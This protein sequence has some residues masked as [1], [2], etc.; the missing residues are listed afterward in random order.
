MLGLMTNNDAKIHAFNMLTQTGANQLAVVPLNIRSDAVVGMSANPDIAG[1]RVT[2]LF[3]TCGPLTVL[4]EVADIAKR[5]GGSF[6]MPEAPSL[7]KG[8]GGILVPPPGMEVPD[9]SKLKIR[10]ESDVS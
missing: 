2:T 9:L 7:G 3:T 10:G 1:Q 6:E 5:L 4:G 8:G